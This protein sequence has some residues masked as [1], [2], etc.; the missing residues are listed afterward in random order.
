MI[1]CNLLGEMCK[2][3]R[4]TWSCET[5]DEFGGLL[6]E[7]EQDWREN[8]APSAASDPWPDM[9][10]FEHMRALFGGYIIQADEP[11]PFDPDVDY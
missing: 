10:S 4:G 3:D 11:P 1:V 5:S 2:V 8:D 7:I 9:T 6:N